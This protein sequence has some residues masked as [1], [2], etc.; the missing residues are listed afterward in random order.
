MWARC[1]DDGDVE[2]TT[3][4]FNI[5]QQQHT[6]AIRL[7]P[8]GGS[9]FSAAK[10]L[11]PI[12]GPPSSPSPKNNG[13]TTSLRNNFFS[14]TTTTTSTYAIDAEPDQQASNAKVDDF[15][16]RLGLPAAPVPLL[17][18]TIKTK[19]NGPLVCPQC[20]RGDFPS[21]VLWKAHCRRCTKKDD[22]EAARKEREL[23]GAPPPSPKPQ[24]SGKGSNSG[25]G[26]FGKMN[27]LA[28][29]RQMEVA[30][31]RDRRMKAAVRSCSL[32]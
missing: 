29:L 22:E 7:T 3:H 18:P 23:S 19:A 6:M 13:A 32:F 5:K 27:L 31:D 4:S 26:G 20:G 21:K 1:D 9:G 16:A 28:Q 10:S 12:P 2:N 14:S 8:M 25:F 17:T 15:R 24:S 11:R 30:D